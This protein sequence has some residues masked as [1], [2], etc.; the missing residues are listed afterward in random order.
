MEP[1]Y[2][3]RVHGGHGMVLSIQCSHTACE[4]EVRLNLGKRLRVGGGETRHASA[5]EGERQDSHREAP[6]LLSADSLRATLGCLLSG[7]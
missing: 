6:A 7:Q 5:A 2:D 3:E 1:G 4:H